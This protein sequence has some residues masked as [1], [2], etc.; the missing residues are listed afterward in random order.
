[1]TNI[2]TPDST[3]PDEVASQDTNPL[4]EV[5]RLVEQ[6]NEAEELKKEELAEV[7]DQ[8]AKGFDIDW[9]S[10]ENWRQMVDEWLKMATQA[11]EVKTFPWPGAS[12]VKYPLVS[13]A[14]MQF[15]ARAYPTLVPSD[16][17][18]V[19]PVVI[20]K[21]PNGE[22]LKRA[23]RVA[24]FMN[25]QLLHD[26]ENWE[27]DMD[28]LLIMDAIMGTVFKKTFYDPY[29]E[30]N[31]SKLVD[32]RNL[33]INYDAESLEKAERISERVYLYEREV[34]ERKAMGIYLDIDLGKPTAA[35]L[36][37]RESTADDD[38]IPYFLVEQHTWLD[39]DHDGVKE[40]YV[41]TFHKSTKKVLR[42]APRFDLDG[43]VSR[44]VRNKVKLVRFEPTQFY[45]K[46]GFIPNPESRIYDLGFG[47]LL[48]PINE[49]VNTIVNQLVDS[50]S[51]SNLQSGF[52]G[53]G[54]RMK[55]FAGCLPGTT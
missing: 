38:T 27:E 3:S 44:N 47:H 16:G 22:K 41:V 54:L 12:N 48:G 55:G 6:T 36:D 17:K 49:S 34:D 19:K 31:V 24:T 26:M 40:P 25:W 35:D 20:G 53:K 29:T 42:I 21:D 28:R 8:C 13:V 32:P 23:E 37:G 50:G 7:G 45:T 18:V 33:V 15:S 51:I 2:E 52:I 46:Y 11:M 30:K 43:V 4:A 1:M 9:A 14:A 5:K 39:L 10:T